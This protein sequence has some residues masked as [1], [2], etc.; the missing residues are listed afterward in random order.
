VTS[1]FVRVLIHSILFV[2][3]VVCGLAAFSQSAK[4]DA[5][6]RFASGVVET[7]DGRL[8]SGVEVRLTN[9]GNATTS[10]AG[11]FAVPI[12]RHLWTG[13]P[14]EISLSNDWVVTLPWEGRTF[15]PVN[16]DEVIHVRV[17][18]KG[19]PI[20]LTDPELVKQIV[21]SLASLGE[22]GRASDI[23]PDESL[24]DKAAALGFSVGQVKLAI[25]EWNKKVQ[26]PYEKGL[27]ALYARR[28][29]DAGRY[30]RQAINSSDEEQIEKFLSLAYAQYQLGLYSD[31]EVSL[32]KAREIEP[33][34]PIVLDELGHTLET[35]ARYAEGEQA[36]Q[37]ALAIYERAFGPDNAKVARELNGIAV[38]YVAQGRYA[39]AEP[40]YRR[41]LAMREKNPGSENLNL[42]LQLSNL[43][44]LYAHEGKYAEA[45]PL[46][47]RSIAITEKVWDPEHLQLAAILNNLALLYVHEGKYAEAEPLCKRS[48]AISEK[49]LGPD[50][51]NVAGR[52]N[53]L[54]GV[55][56]EQGKYAEAEPLF[57]RALATSQRTLGPSHPLVANYLNNLAS[58]YRREGKYTLA[59]QLL[60]QAMAIH[61]KTLGPSHPTLAV[62]L[63]NLA[64]LYRQERKYDYAET[65]YQRAL[66]IDEKALGPEHPDLAALL[67]NLG[68]VYDH[69][70]KSAEAVPLFERAIGIDEKAS[71]PDS[72]KLIASLKNL[73]VSLRQLGRAAEAEVY[74]QQAE[75]IQ[76]IASQQNPLPASDQK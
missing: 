58:L 76:G 54:A 1:Q 37:L 42:A 9:L 68:V 74:E 20:L 35:E 49:A 46:Y 53:A 71:G 13:D 61:E 30:I 57:K 14:I 16:P 55:Y 66:T 7:S 12:P 50:H 64:E 28:Y 21:S 36:Y 19:D 47:K 25:E 51:P 41:A 40:L 39:D 75:R 67:N 52:I 43:G 62:D 6:T 63:S 23:Q 27:A 72:P 59:E 73:A 48:I 44:V 2:A 38:L 5:P 10:D 69:T 22:A 70:G 60:R 45:E 11:A 15:V 34:N 56:S 31:A 18:R 17:A 33:D 26:E 65:L 32:V 8:L 24:A 4:P 3:T 29:G